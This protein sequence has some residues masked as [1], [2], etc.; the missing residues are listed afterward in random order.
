[1]SNIIDFV[2]PA[3]ARTYAKAKNF[4][5]STNRLPLRNSATG[6]IDSW[7]HI[8]D[9]GQLVRSKRKYLLP[10]VDNT[11]DVY[12][13]TSQTTYTK[14]GGAP[15]SFT[16]EITLEIG[17]DSVID[18]GT[19]GSFTRV[20]GLTIRYGRNRIVKR[21]EI[22]QSDIV[23][24]DGTQT[25]R[26][27]LQMVSGTGSV[28]LEGTLIN[29]NQ[30][31]DALWI[32]DVD[33]SPKKYV[34]QFCKCVGISATDEPDVTA[35]DHP[36]WIQFQQNNGDYDETELHV[37]ETYVD[38]SYQGITTNDGFKRLELE[39]V[40]Y[41]GQPGNWDDSLTPGY[42]LGIFTGAGD[43]VRE[44]VFGEDVEVRRTLDPG[45]SI[46]PVF[47]ETI[48]ESGYSIVFD[49]ALPDPW[50]LRDDYGTT[51]EAPEDIVIGTI[52]DL[53][54]AIELHRLDA[55]NVHNIANTS[56]IVLG[57]NHGAVDSTP[58]P[59]AADGSAWPGKVVWSGTVA[60]VNAITGDMVVLS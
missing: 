39:H 28:F 21:G 32:N 56:Q 3:D 23:V 30:L 38:S 45:S 22:D 18:L 13:V 6:K 8:N 25:Q 34:M 43:A 60:P 16:G 59:L 2:R 26:K 37:Y 55:T 29:G 44:I 15:V 10:T 46:G 19:W 5:L 42:F 41:D 27:G 47:P 50:W 12:V 48:P 24:G 20:G 17:K 36:D 1:M 40:F 57:V 31:G 7:L 9:Q 51:F 35:G 33:S 49:S 52:E 54:T 11:W 14:N 53:E 4:L 58:R